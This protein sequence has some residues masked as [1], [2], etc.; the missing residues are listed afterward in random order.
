MQFGDVVMMTSVQLV[1]TC[2]KGAKDKATVGLKANP[3]T[4]M[5]FLYLGGIPAEQ[6]HRLREDGTVEELFK[7]MGYV[8]DPDVIAALAA[9]QAE[10]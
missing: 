5:V 4:G 10:G 6:E 3:N 9:E 8:P 7:V 1:S 2:K